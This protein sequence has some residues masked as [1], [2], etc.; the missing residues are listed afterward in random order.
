MCNITNLDLKTDA[1]KITRSET[2]RNTTFT[3]LEHAH[4]STKS[5]DIIGLT[6]GC[7]Y[8]ENVTVNRYNGYIRGTNMIV[9]CSGVISWTLILIFVKLNSLR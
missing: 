9:R 3:W 1:C 2:S 4:P 6:V 7:S 5:R 8:S